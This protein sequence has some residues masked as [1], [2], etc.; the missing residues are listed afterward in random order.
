MLSPDNSRS[1][2]SSTTLA[3]S[4]ERKNDRIS[5]MCIRTWQLL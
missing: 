2:L 3:A 5:P 1:R 4:A